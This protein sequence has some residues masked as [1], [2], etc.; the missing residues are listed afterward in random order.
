MSLYN[1]EDDS[2]ELDDDSSAFAITPTQNL[3]NSE[4]PSVPPTPIPTPIPSPP[5][6]PVSSFAPSN[7]APIPE[8]S[9]PNN[10]VTPPVEIKEIELPITDNTSGGAQNNIL[11][12]YS[13]EIVSMNEDKKI[14]FDEPFPSANLTSGSD[15]MDKLSAL[16]YSQL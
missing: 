14:T 12:S 5:P 15:N 6:S 1:D 3:E 7:P 8:V 10:P 2:A 16:S 9:E 4:P 11:D 13:G